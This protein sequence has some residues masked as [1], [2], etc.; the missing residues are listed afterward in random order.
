MHTTHSWH[1]HLLIK[2][3]SST[4]SP[5]GQSIVLYL[6]STGSAP[7]D[8]TSSLVL[9]GSAG[10]KVMRADSEHWLHFCFPQSI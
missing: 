4:S 7:V 8:Q 1:K 5:S 6:M 9:V 3:L 10:D 2:K